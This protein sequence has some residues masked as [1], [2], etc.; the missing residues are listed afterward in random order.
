MKDEEH[1]KGVSGAGPALELTDLQHIQSESSFSVQLPS[2]ALSSRASP[3]VCTTSISDLPMGQAQ[4]GRD[5]ISSCECHLPGPSISSLHQLPGLVMDQHN[6][7]QTN[8]VPKMHSTMLED[9]N[10]IAIPV[11]AMNRHQQDFTTTKKVTFM[12]FIVTLVF[13]ATVVITSAMMNFKNKEIRLFFQNFVLINYMINPIIY[14]IVNSRFRESL[15]RFV[16]SI[17][18]GFD[19]D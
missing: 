8:P 12:L 14:G 15:V 9:D 1:H 18:H 4:T 11:V 16:R 3:Y 6:I 19:R 7:E 5:S 13:F 2:T 10:E 17:G